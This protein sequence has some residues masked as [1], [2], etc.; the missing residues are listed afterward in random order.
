M[1]GA[2]DDSNSGNVALDMPVKLEA[3]GVDCNARPRVLRQML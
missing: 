1:P 2:D 3:P